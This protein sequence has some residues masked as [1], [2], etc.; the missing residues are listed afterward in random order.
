MGEGSDNYPPPASAADAGRPSTSG[1]NTLLLTRSGEEMA[2]LGRVEWLAK[3]VSSWETF[4]GAYGAELKVSE[5]FFDFR[6]WFLLL[7][8]HIFLFCSLYFKIRM[9]CS[10]LMRCN[11][12]PLLRLI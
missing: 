4:S 6:Y 1:L 3:L 5:F 9:S 10:V 11:L 12:L 8:S 7:L 2:Q